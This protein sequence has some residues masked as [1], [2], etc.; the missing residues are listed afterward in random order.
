[1]NVGLFPL[2]SLSLPTFLPKAKAAFSF[3]VHSYVMNIESPASP[4]TFEDDPSKRSQPVPSLIT[5]LLVGCRRRAVI[6]SWKDGEPR[7]VKV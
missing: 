7:E 1:M 5:I 3:A 4:S 6:Y 2:P